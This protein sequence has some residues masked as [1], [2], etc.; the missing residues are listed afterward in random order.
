M[1]NIVVSENP[2]DLRALPA[3][4]LEGRLDAYTHG[5]VFAGGYAGPAPTFDETLEE[6]M[7]SLYA[8]TA[9]PR[10]SGVQIKA[11]MNPLA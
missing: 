9:M 4:A 3:D 11:P 1:S 8:S 10:L 5:G 7:A 6:R 2:D